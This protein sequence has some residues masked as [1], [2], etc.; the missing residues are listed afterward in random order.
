MS[1]DTFSF[2]G[3]LDNLA[4]FDTAPMTVKSDE[5]SAAV[6]EVWE[7]WLE[8]L[9]STTRNRVLLSEARRKKI[10]KAV[11]A[12]GVE[13]CKKAILGCA[14]SD[15]HMGRNGSGT[16]YDDIELI[17]RNEQKIEQF[18]SMYNNRSDW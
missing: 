14:S 17:L 12:Y 16:K 6:L 1:N 5:P 11:K 4:L 7:F 8:T 15:F 2:S 18:R 13:D 9:R 3:E 10:E